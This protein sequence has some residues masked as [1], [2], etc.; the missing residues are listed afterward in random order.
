MLGCSSAGLNRYRAEGGGATLGEDDPVDSGTIGHTKESAE[1]L[2]IFNAIESKHETGL[3]SA[4]GR[5]R[6]VI[7][8]FYREKFLGTDHGNHALMR[9]CTSQLGQL[10]AGFL[11]NGDAGSPALGDYLFE[12]C[13]L[14]FAGYD[15]VIETSPACPER[16]FNRVDAVKNFHEG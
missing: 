14:P 2:G 6:R 15:D 4:C 5:S 7:E 11:A 10:L 9:R 3:G 16:L 8:V 13:I 1:V 12:A